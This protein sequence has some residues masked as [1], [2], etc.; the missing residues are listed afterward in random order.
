M[1]EG[2][3]RL[4]VLSC[5]FFFFFSS[6]RR[7]TR[8]WRDWSSDVCSSDLIC[9]LRDA[10]FLFIGSSGLPASC[11]HRA[12]EKK[13]GVTEHADATG[14]QRKCSYDGAG[15]TRDRKSVV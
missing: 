1:T 4:R 12:Q 2:K 14:R 15:R 13:S 10:A 8:Y 9:M 6:R 11:D 5:G 3:K 7:H